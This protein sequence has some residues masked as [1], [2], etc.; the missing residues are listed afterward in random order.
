LAGGEICILKY[1]SG[2]ASMEALV[3]DS[4]TLKAEGF[5][6]AVGSAIA[7]HWRCPTTPTHGDH[8][9]LQRCGMEDSWRQSLLSCSVARSVWAL[10]DEGIT[11]HVC[12]NEDMSAKRWLFAM[13]GS[14]SRE[15][16]DFARVAI[17]LWAIWYARR[18]IIHEEEFQSPLLTHLFIERYLQDLSII[19][20]SNKM[21]GRGKGTEHPRWIK[22]EAGC[23]KLNV[24]AA[25]SKSRPGGAVGVV[26]RGEDGS[27]L[28]A[29]SLTINGVSDPAILDALACREAIALAHDLQL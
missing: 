9:L 12:M 14:L 21:E 22:P 16:D 23:A 19:G 13:M 27:F 17:T 24:D 6:M 11:E 20:S 26:C 25:L 1:R 28:G 4:S 29:S 18:K 10:A 3:A 15:R 8:K 2:G 5:S 7:A